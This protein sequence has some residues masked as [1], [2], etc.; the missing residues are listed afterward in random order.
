MF[1][2]VGPSGLIQTR[3]R[4][5]HK[6]LN[7][8]RKAKASKTTRIREGGPT[9]KVSKLVE[10]GD[11]VDYDGLIN[12]LNGTCAKSGAVEIRRLMEITLPHREQM[13]QNNPQSI[14]IV[15]KKF[16]ECGFMVNVK[17]KCH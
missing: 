7:T 12:R 13:R 3:L 15:Y 17:L 5:I 8:T 10:L 11:D 1:D 14:L 16:S 4:N 2:E 9:A 6:N